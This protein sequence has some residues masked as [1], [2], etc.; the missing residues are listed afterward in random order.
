MRRQ[1]EKE[2]PAALGAWHEV[3]WREHK[4]HV[5]QNLLPV[6]RMIATTA[7]AVDP[8]AM[9][10][11]IASAAAEREY[12]AARSALTGAAGAGVTAVRQ[13]LDQWDG[14]RATDAA[15][16]ERLELIHTFTPRSTP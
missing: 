3:F 13:L 2:D 10:R 16:R 1:L 8:E 11:A 5:R 9:A 12:A 15:Q 7:G 4:A 6:A 14:A